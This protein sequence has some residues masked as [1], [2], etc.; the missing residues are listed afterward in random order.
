MAYY[1]QHNLQSQMVRATPLC[2]SHESVLE[3]IDHRLAS[4][5][6][7]FISLEHLSHSISA[8]CYYSNFKQV[9]IDWEVS[10]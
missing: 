6:V 1:Y 10:F 5:S 3:T 2:H 8:Q 7:F 4:L 9:N